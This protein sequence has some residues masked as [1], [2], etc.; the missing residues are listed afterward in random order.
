VPH[1]KEFVDVI[2]KKTGKVPTARTWFGFASTWSCALAANDAK[3]LDAIRM[4]KALQN[5]KLPPEVGLMPNQPF[6]RA[7]Q[8]Q[9]I[10]SLYVGHAQ[11]KGSAPD[12]LFKVEQVVNGVE[13]AG[14]LEESG[15]KMS[16]PA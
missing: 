8:N 14:P 13:A 9:L 15:C 7:N 2:M 4:A 10:G 3:S 6:Y 12:D 5:M 1:V 16:W 11:A